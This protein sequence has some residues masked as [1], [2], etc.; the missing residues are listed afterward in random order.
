MKV[1]ARGDHPDGIVRRVR[2]EI[3][4]WTPERGPDW[5]DLLRRADARPFEKLRIYAIA[6]FALAAIIL[7]AFLAMSALNIGS[8][9]AGTPVVTRIQIER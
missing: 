6:S 8:S 2:T 4:S 1:N 5:S 9:L 7:V 3:S